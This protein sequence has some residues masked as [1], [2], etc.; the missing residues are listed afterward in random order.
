MWGH[1]WTF[2]A[3]HVRYFGGIEQTTVVDL[4]KITTAMTLRVICET[5]TSPLALRVLVLG[6]TTETLNEGLKIYI[7][8]K[9]EAAS[10]TRLC[11]IVPSISTQPAITQ[12]AG[13]PWTSIGK[14]DRKWPPE[15]PSWWSSSKAHLGLRWGMPSD[16]LRYGWDP[17]NYTSQGKR[18]GV[19][20]I[21]SCWKLMSSKTSR[22]WTNENILYQ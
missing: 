22:S 21:L 19:Q 10:E 5:S 17:T 18:N 15:I 11:A 12:A 14:I 3:S 20:G 8:T 2:G 13:T 1:I 7:R 9:P 16:H 6:V 4:R